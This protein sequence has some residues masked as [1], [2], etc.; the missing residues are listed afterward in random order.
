M[1]ITT[2]IP[3]HEI[4]D[5]IEKYLKESIQSVVEQIDVNGKI[6]LMIVYPTEID[7]QIRNIG[8][9]FNIEIKYVVNEG[10]TEYQSQVNLA[11][12]NVDT[13]FFVVLEFDDV[14]STTYLKNLKKHIESYKDVDIFL[15][16]IIEVDGD[17]NALKFTNELLWSQQFVG[18]SD[19]LGYLNMN[20]LKQYSDFKLSGG[21][22]KKSTFMKIG[23]YKENIKLTFM[24]EL[25]MRVLNN[26]YVIMGIPK[27]GYRHLSGREN[28][29]FDIYG[30][31]MN[32]KERK[33]WF[34]TAVKES[35]FNTDR[36]IDI[37][38]FGELE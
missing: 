22:I 16:M 8:S 27:L 34:D 17:N 19:E 30:K 12:E 14:F 7:T 31:T 18:E 28:S 20:A 11:V 33:F 13:E 1:N 37:P 3:I 24:Y 36:N 32:I 29:L 35:N 6:K 23:K 2:I 10:N 15:P 5:D 21:A 25:L 4:N 9:Q 26:G 38:V